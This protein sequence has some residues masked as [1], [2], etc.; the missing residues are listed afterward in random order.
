[1]SKSLSLEHCS[2]KRVVIEPGADVV[3]WRDP[4][5]YGPKLDFLTAPNGVIVS[6]L[7]LGGGGRIVGGGAAWW[8][9]VHGFR[10]KTIYLTSVGE[11][12]SAHATVALASVTIASTDAV[13]LW[14]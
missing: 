6:N 14:L 2:N 3:I 7:T 1:M 12:A 11:D 8:P 10:P 4:S 9:D 5:T 13:R